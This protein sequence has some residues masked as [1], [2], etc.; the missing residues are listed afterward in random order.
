VDSAPG[1]HVV[2]IQDMDDHA[3]RGAFV[4]EVHEK[5]SKSPW[6][7]V[8]G[9]VTDGAIGGGALSRSPMPTS[10]LWILEGPGIGIGV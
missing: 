1:P 2:V 3:G 4:G 10:A 6:L 5:H 7:G 8:V 9:V